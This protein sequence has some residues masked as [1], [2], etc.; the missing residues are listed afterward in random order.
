MAYS[1]FD[2]A[3]DTLQFCISELSRNKKAGTKVLEKALEKYRF[4]RTHNELRKEV[5]VQAAPQTHVQFSEEFGDKRLW[6]YLQSGKGAFN[7]TGNRSDYA[8]MDHVIG[9]DKARNVA[10]ILMIF[11]A[12]LLGTFHFTAV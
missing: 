10:L 3:E 12:A 1:Q 8:H 4:E 11:M 9:W 6:D 7:E 2:A 5:H